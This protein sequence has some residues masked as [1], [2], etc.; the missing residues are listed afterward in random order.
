MAQGQQGQQSQQQQQQ[1][2]RLRGA[3]PKKLQQALESIAQA[4]EDMRKSAAA[5]QQGG[6]QNDADARRAADRL[7]EGLRD[8]ASMRSQ[9]SSGQ[10][11]DLAR[12]ADELSKRQQQFEGD[13]RRAYTQSEGN[14]TRQQANQLADQHQAEVADVKKLEE[15]M[16]NAVRDLMATQRD[17]STKMRQAL[18]DMQQ[19]EIERDMQRNA[20]YIRRGMAEYAAMSEPTFT[21]GLNDVRDKLN[22]IQ[23]QLG[24]GGPGGKNDKAGQQ[25]KALQD[26]LSSVEQLRQQVEA[27]L[28]QLHAQNGQNGQN[29]QDGQPSGQQRQ[30]QQ[31]S[32]DGQNGQQGQQAGQQGKQGG[33][34]GQQGQGQQGGQQ[35]QQGQGGQQQGGQQAGGGNN[36]GGSY[37]GGYNNGGNYGGD[38]YG[39]RGG[40]IRDTDIQTTYRNA[41]QSLQQ[42]QQQARGD[43]NATRDIN[44]LIRDFR[45]FDPYNLNNDPL[46][47]QRIQAAL[48]NIEQVEMELRRKVEQANG[49]DGS[50]RSPGSEPA[51]QGY[52]DAVAEYFRKL[53]KTSKQQ[54]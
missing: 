23:K 6:P 54:Q 27:R 53:S 36:S 4:E 45:Q 20:D 35:G 21:A 42:L 7:N 3:D 37:N 1:S 31:L 51:P 8:L 46:L 9:Q 33:Q 17:A 5:Q 49:G 13:L 40:P 44:N 29:G 38:N 32:R 12:Q 19:A 11:D 48:G 22:Q 43:A 28:A 24:Q 30:G 39:Y 50:V 2:Q 15:G 18:S 25:D 10:I 52:S 14:M 41:L 34:Q 26:S 47:S 16:Q